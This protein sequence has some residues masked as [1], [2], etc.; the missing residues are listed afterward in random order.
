MFK[1]RLG[2]RENALIDIMGFDITEEYMYFSAQMANGIFRMNMS[3]GGIE[4]LIM[5]EKDKPTD[6]FLY[7]DVKLDGKKVWC[8]PY[9]SKEIMIFDIDT[10]TCEFISIPK[11]SGNGRDNVKFNSLYEYEE[12]F[13]LI[14]SEYPAI[15]KV[16]KKTYEV[17]FIKW[18]E[19]LLQK[20]PDFYEVNNFLAIC[21]D[22]EV[23]NDSMYLLAENVVIKY[24]MKSDNF[25]FIRI[26]KEAKLYCG[27]TRYY[28]EFILLDR[29][30]SELVIWNEESNCIRKLDV[31]L[32]YRGL[33]AQD[34]GCPLGIFSVNEQIVVVQAK[35]DYLVL[36]DEK[37]RVRK[38]Q[39]N[40]SGNSRLDL[41]FE[42]Y[43]FGESKL[44]LPICEKNQIMIVDTRDWSQKLL[45]FDTRT[46]EFSSVREKMEEEYIELHENPVYYQLEHFI[47]HIELKNLNKVYSKKTQSNIGKQIYENCKV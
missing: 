36:L 37:W 35:A 25:T 5:S 42:R 4:H 40:V 28:D 15:I 43:K 8:I 17:N 30:D 38:I 24:D 1:W 11:L 2:L 10:K 45:D 47:D 39:L 7:S 44:I 26:N 33:N 27:I 29:A 12:W 41:K 23:V 13:I 34:D 32:G 9:A 46:L 14:P 22:F 31:N 16:N 21:A 6:G 3:T 19:K 20:Y 18:E